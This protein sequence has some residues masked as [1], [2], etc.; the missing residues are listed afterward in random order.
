MNVATIIRSR[1]DRWRDVMAKALARHGYATVDDIFKQCATTEKVFFESGKAFA[2]VDVIDYPRER[3]LL[4]LLAGGN[5]MESID[6][7]E[8][9]IREFGQAIGATKAVFVGRRGLKRVM[10]KRGWKEPF[11][12]MEKEIE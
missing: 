6:E 2:V 9:V 11:V 10:A 3:R 5:D 12:Y 8:P 7:L 4:I 1:F